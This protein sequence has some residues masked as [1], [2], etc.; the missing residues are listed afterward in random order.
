[1][2]TAE[3]KFENRSDSG[4]AARFVKKFEGQIRFCPD[5][6]RWLLWQA[7]RWKIDETGEIY[8]YARSAV[9]DIYTEA[10]QFQDKTE[11]L[12]HAAFALRSESE[13]SLK[14]MVSLARYE[15]IIP[16]R[17]VALDDHPNKLNLLNGI[18]DLETGELIDHAPEFYFTKIIPYVFDLEETAPAWEKFLDEITGNDEALKN[19]LQQITGYCLTGSAREQVFFIFWGDGRNGKSTFIKVLLELLGPWA[20]QTPA[21]TF[22]LKNGSGGFSDLARLADKRLVCAIETDEGGKLAEGLIKTLSGNDRIATRHHYQE[23]FEYEPGFKT[24]LTTNHKPRIRGN[25]LAIWRRI[26]LVPFTWTIPEEKVDPDIFEK[27]KAEMPGILTWA[28]KGCFEWLNHGK[29][30][31]PAVVKDAVKEY[32]QE[33]DQVSRFIDDCCERGADDDHES[34]K[35]LYDSYKTWSIENGEHYFSANKFGRRLQDLGFEKIHTMIGNTYKKI[36]LTEKVSNE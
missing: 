29:L 27:L 4:N 15:H 17:R 6:K 33:Q 35:N 14:A 21:E 10:G 16:I 30:E 28:V 32:Q 5:L 22:L 8:Q 31:T 23:F 24:I 12:A 7:D 9:Q 20:A 13:H 2:K 18:L 25:D 1:M 36:Q 19:F 34:A 11:R 26:R 3:T